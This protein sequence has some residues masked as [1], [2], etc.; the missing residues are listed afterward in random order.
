ML[1]FGLKFKAYIN[2]RMEKARNA[3]VRVKG[4]LSKFG[5]T[6][7]LTRRIYIVVV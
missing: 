7:N 1:D 4:I 6:P 3:E 5:L 2:L